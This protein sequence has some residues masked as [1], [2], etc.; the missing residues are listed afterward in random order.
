LIEAAPSSDALASLKDVIVAPA[1]D[2]LTQHTA[3]AA[4][5][6]P[7]TRAR[8]ASD[9]PAPSRVAQQFRRRREIVA[10]RG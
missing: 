1:T 7:T 9:S 3:H 10:R 2:I 8:F 4:A 5:L 6:P